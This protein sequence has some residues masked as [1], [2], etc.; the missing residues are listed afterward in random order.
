MQIYS[1]LAGLGLLGGFGIGFVL[2]VAESI[3]IKRFLDPI[4]PYYRLDSAIFPFISF[5]LCSAVIVF[6]SN[7]H[8]L[9]L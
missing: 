6:S 5:G 3:A 1:E 9:L 7:S 4:P 2:G 8:I